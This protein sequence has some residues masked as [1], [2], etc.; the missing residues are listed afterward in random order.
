MSNVITL[1]LPISPSSPDIW[2]LFLESRV[3]E[4]T[5]VAYQSRL[6]RVSER[7]GYDSEAR[8]IQ[9]FLSEPT[10]T[11]SRLRESLQRDGI[12][13][14][15]GIHLMGFL[16]VLGRFAWEQGLLPFCPHI[17]VGRRERCHVDRIVTV[18]ELEIEAITRHIDS[19]PEVIK[20]LHRSALEGLYFRGLR[21]EELLS[22]R[23]CDL[24]R[25][26]NQVSIEEKFHKGSHVPI[27][28]RESFIKELSLLES[29]LLELEPRLPVTQGLFI[30]PATF[31]TRWVRAR[32]GNHI[33]PMDDSTL[34]RLVHGWGDAI[35]INVSPHMFRHGIA[36]HL[37][38]K[39]V[40]VRD[41]AIFLRQST[42]E[43]QR[44]YFDRLETTA[45]AVMELI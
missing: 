1:P 20:P 41:L 38:G 12:G 31:A 18:T 36:T 3:S 5:R 13:Q 9:G 43:V 42:S 4:K 44:L 32:N 21:L 35:G 45:R 19:L 25:V 30:P 28:V 16:S 14:S 37:A 22:I 15:D 39:G 7:C 29:R 33:K 24:D 17:E 23:R 40:S 11:A 10:T 8:F 27:P 2:T 34:N 6:R 26:H